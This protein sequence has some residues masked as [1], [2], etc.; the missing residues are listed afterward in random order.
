MK[1]QQKTSTKLRYDFDLSCFFFSD[2]E[3]WHSDC[4]GSI[5]FRFWLEKKQMILFEVIEGLASTI[6]STICVIE[7][8]DKKLLPNKDSFSFLSS[9]VILL[10]MLNWMYELP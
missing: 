9:I 6:L 3:K 10:C 2:K 1:F 4:S 8:A 7:M 5:D